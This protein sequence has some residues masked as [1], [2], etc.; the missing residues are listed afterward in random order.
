M[1]DLGTLNY[2]LGLEISHDS[3]DYFLSHTKYASDLLTRAA[4]TDCKT[5]STSIDPQTRL[6]P[7]DGT[8]LSNAT[9]YRQLVGNLIYFT[10]TR[11][12]LSYAVHIVSQYMLASR[13][14]HY[15]A[16]L[17]ILRYLKST[18]FYGL[19]Y[20]SLSFLKHHA[21]SDTDWA[22]D[23]TDRR[24]T[25]GFCFFLGDSLISWRSKKQALTARS[26]TKAEYRAL[27]GTT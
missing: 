1:K 22:G 23:P 8:L 27:A 14:P 13:T 19:H 24:S 20:S 16:L 12:D 26:S 2:F 18:L 25:T 3:F 15:D 17:R 10:V 9:L 4:L 11:P 7:L 6:T 5:T 21:Y